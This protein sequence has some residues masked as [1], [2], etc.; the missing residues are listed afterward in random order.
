V[1]INLLD[2]VTEAVRIQNAGINSKNLII[3]TGNYS[4][5]KEVIFEHPIILP[6]NA[7][8]EELL[9]F[10]NSINS[11]KKSIISASDAIKALEVAE[12]IEEKIK[13]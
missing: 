7:I 1:S 10:Y 2:K 9:A 13:G 8:K 6:T 12:E 3:D 4:P 5:K 11:D